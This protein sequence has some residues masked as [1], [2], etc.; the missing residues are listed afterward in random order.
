MTYLGTITS[1]RQITL[2]AELFAALRFLEGDRVIISSDGDGVKIRRALSLVDELAGSVKVSPK[3]LKV[4]IDEAIKIAK[5][6]HF[7]QKYRKLSK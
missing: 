4:P 6:R 5:K 1:K 7:V 3:L 2:P